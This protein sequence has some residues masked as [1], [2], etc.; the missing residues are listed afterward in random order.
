MTELWTHILH[1]DVHSKCSGKLQRN[2]A[3][4]KHSKQQKLESIPRY[5]L[6]SVKKM[7]SNHKKNFVGAHDTSNIRCLLEN[8]KVTDYIIES[9]HSSE[10]IALEEEAIMEGIFAL[11]SRVKGIL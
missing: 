3:K 10:I 11:I 7:D 6:K 9:V 4:I 2:K 1:H 5:E 8:N